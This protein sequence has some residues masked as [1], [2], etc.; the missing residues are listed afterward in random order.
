MLHNAICRGRY[1]RVYGVG[2]SMGLR[3]A[4]NSMHGLQS[5]GR[6]RTPFI[7]PTAS[8]PSFPPALPL[9]FTRPHN[10]RKTQ[11]GSTQGSKAGFRILSEKEP[12][13]PPPRGAVRAGATG[14]YHGKSEARKAR[15]HLWDILSKSTPSH[16]KSKTKLNRRLWVSLK[17]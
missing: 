2:D 9:H 8:S 14:A 5:Y 11:T 10:Y 13:L 4:Q 7:L 3:K 1:I 15:R 6:I 16:D 12:T 17:P